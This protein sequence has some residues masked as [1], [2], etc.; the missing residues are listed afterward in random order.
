MF[1]TSMTAVAV[2]T[3]LAGSIESSPKWQTDYLTAITQAADQKKPVAVF[4]GEGTNGYAKLVTDGVISSKTEQL[5]K[6]AYV[7]LYIDTT[8]ETGKKLA[9]SFNLNQGV[10][11]S[12][13][14]GDLQALRHSGK[15]SATELNRYVEKYSDVQTVTTT[16]S[17][18]SAMAPA[19]YSTGGY[20]PSMSSCPG[21][22]C[23]GTVMGGCPGGNCGGSYSGGR[24]R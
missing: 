10:V 24:R 20:Y 2:A 23:G 13:R 17:N 6:S 7:C 18:V 8:T 9:K 12:D 16:E 4:I 15:V 3:L 1:T 5:L 19:G 11:I 21:G 22:N 14:T